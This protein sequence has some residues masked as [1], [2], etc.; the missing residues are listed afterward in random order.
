M[1][2][3]LCNI[4]SLYEFDDILSSS[5]AC[6][7]FL[8]QWSSVYGK[9]IRSSLI[10][11]S[12]FLSSL[13]YFRGE[14]NYEITDG[15]FLELCDFLPFEVV[16]FLACSLP[17]TEPYFLVFFDFWEATLLESPPLRVLFFLFLRLG[18]IDCI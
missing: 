6:A 13:I 3:S 7:K 15:Y 18:I 2:S 14:L 8:M 1:A 9:F 16:Y 5:F 12:Y 4:S 10:S 17:I 11:S